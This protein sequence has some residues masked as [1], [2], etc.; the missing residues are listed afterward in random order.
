ML[1]PI[2]TILTLLI[3]LLILSSCTK[4][5]DDSNNHATET[6]EIHEENVKSTKTSID[7]IDEEDAKALFIK[8]TEK[9]Y[10]IEYFTNLNYEVIEGV[11]KIA[12]V[13]TIYKN[14]K[15]YMTEKGYQ[16]MVLKPYDH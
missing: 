14:I 16:R 6:S 8:Y 4:T 10:T 15:P 5:Q 11:K 7:F 1:R 13:E 3:F 9:L 2:R 12:A